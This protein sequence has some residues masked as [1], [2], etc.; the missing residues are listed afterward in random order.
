MHE[1]LRGCA[2]VASPSV[3]MDYG[4]R[5]NAVHQEATQTFGGSVGDLAQADASDSLPIFLSCHHNQSLFLP[6][7]TE[8]P[9]LQ[10]AQISLITST[11]RASKSRPGR[12][13]ARRNL[14][15]HI[16]AVS[17]FFSPSTR[18]SPNALA[19]FFWVVSHHIARN[20]TGNGV[21]VS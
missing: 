13:I 14:C 5:L 12:T 19:P 7:P 9:F 1:A 11:L 4:A 6:L 21:R 2:T 8:N 10:S 3:R 20:Q 17:Y 18:C 15:S 16:H